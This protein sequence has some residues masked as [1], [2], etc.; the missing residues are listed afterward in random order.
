MVVLLSSIIVVCCCC[1]FYS[2]VVVAVCT[3][4]L[5]VLRRAIGGSGGGVVGKARGF[6][7]TAKAGTPV[8]VPRVCLGPNNFYREIT[9]ARAS[10][11]IMVLIHHWRVF[12]FEFRRDMPRVKPALRDKLTSGVPLIN[13]AM[14]LTTGCS[15]FRDGL[16][17]T[18]HLTSW[19][20]GARSCGCL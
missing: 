5:G 18:V 1:C 17:F 16:N 15:Y 11:A 20:R 12:C 9:A 19:S 3:E 7:C 6:P 8:A 2:S 4:T 14:T 13:S 10:L